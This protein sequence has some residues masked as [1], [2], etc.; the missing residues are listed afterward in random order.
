MK[1]S[2]V[3]AVMG[4]QRD[5]IKGL[6]PKLKPRKTNGNCALGIDIGRMKRQK[7]KGIKVKTSGKRGGSATEKEI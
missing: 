1:T 7:V 5:G 2:K 6:R 3:W 4:T